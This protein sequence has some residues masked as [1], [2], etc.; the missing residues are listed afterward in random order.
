ME[1]L[2]LSVEPLSE[3]FEPLC[4]HSEPLSGTFLE[5]GTFLSVEPLW[6]LGKPGSRIPAAAPNHP[7]VIVAR[8]HAFEAVEE[9]RN[10]C[11]QPGEKSSEKIV[12][13]KISMMALPMLGT[14]TAR[15][16]I[17]YATNAPSHVT[18]RSCENP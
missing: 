2:N 4:L 12:F 10:A 14:K 16:P 3:G 9:K 8:P 5:P 18:H 13:L 6:N 1:S 11:L 15:P 7:E 17:H